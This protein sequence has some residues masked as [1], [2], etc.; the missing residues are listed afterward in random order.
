MFNNTQLSIFNIDFGD[1][2]SYISKLFDSI[3]SHTQIG[4]FDRA[5]ESFIKTIENDPNLPPD[6]KAVLIYNS[7]KMLKEWINQYNIYERSKQYYLNSHPDTFPERV[8]DSQPKT[9]S[10]GWVDSFFDKAKLISEESLQILW[11]QI[12]AGERDNPGTYSLSLLHTL[13]VISKDDAESFALLKSF[14]ATDIHDKNIKHVFI[15]F[16]T[17]RAYYESRGITEDVLYRLEYL[18]LIKCEFKNEF[19][20]ERKKYLIYGDK[21]IEV[22]GDKASSHHI[23]KTGNVVLTQDG[24]KLMDLV[25]DEVFTKI[26]TFAFYDL[27][28]FFKKRHCT[29]IIID[30]N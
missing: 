4:D 25:Q 9:I 1:P 8:T 20:F 12:L 23:I 19:E 5:H 15:F 24:A 30:D 13:S 11:A 2:I 26:D 29:T 3:K 18:G 22:L 10:Q 14:Y 17:N 7:R 21:K 28:G 16:S 27:I 6:Y